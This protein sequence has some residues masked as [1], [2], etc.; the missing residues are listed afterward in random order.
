MSYRGRDNLLSGD[1]AADAAFGTGSWNQQFQDAAAFTASVKADPTLF[2]KF[3]LQGYTL[4]TTGHSLGGGI[5]Q[6]MA[7]MFGVDGASFDAPEANAVANSAGFLQAKAQYA[8]DSA[9]QVGSQFFNYVAQGSVISFV[10]THVGQD[11]TIVNLSDP[12]SA[13][14]L[15]GL[16][17]AMTGGAALGLLGLLGSSNVLANHPM[18]GIERAMYIAAGLD[19]ALGDGS[20]K[21]ATI[22]MSQATGRPW[23]GAGSEPNVVVFQ[24][25][26]NQTKAIIQRNGDLWTLS[27]PDQSTVITLVPPATA[28][29]APTCTMAA[30]DTN[31][32]GKVSGVEL[33]G[34]YAWSGTNEDGVAQTTE[35][36]TLANA[37]LSGIRAG[38]YS[39]YTSGNARYRNAVQNTALA[40]GQINELQKVPISD[41]ANSR[42]TDNVY[43]DA[44]NQSRYSVAA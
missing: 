31:A 15:V 35:L 40:P 42:A 43:L 22:S 11:K 2:D 25:A 30:L 27:T 4:L 20:L 34:L 10:G 16:A 6:L 7:K 23:T 13:P 3:S 39:F 44:A 24:D 9:G 1:A 36:T 41:Y 8:P 18:G 12:S 32:D 26:N 19:K 14:L 38:D 33:H 28:G 21:M 37:G 17:G 5:A 29:G